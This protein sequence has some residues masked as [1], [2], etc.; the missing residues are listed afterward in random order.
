[1]Q[2]YF[3]NGRKLLLKCCVIEIDNCRLSQPQ[4]VI[5][6]FYRLI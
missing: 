1:M 3:G 2:D 4:F 6:D 5:I